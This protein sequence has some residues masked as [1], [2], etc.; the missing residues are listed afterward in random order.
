MMEEGIYDVDFNANN[1]LDLGRIK[2][3]DHGL[4]K[5]EVLPNSH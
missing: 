1:D 4:A 2:L 3:T 5:E